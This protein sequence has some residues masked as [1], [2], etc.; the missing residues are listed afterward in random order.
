MCLTVASSLSRL[1]LAVGAG[2]AWSRSGLGL[3]RLSRL[4]GCGDRGPPAG[5]F[6]PLLGNRK[7]DRCAGL[8]PAFHVREYTWDAYGMTKQSSRLD[9]HSVRTQE[10]YRRLHLFFV[11]AV[12]SGVCNTQPL[13]HGP[14]W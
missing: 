9:P 5:G 12:G 7:I 8:N 14:T 2:S 13:R 10:N 1:R 11:G 3:G 4:L 6:W